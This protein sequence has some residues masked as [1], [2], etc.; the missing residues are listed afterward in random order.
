MPVSS[1]PMVLVDSLVKTFGRDVRALN[2]VSFQIPAGT[3]LGLLGPNGAGK[4][5][6]VRVLTTLLRPD[7]G[8]AEVAGIDVLANPANARRVIGLA[9]QYAAVDEALTGAENL[10]L[11]GRLNHLSRSE[12]SKRAASLLEQFGLTEARDRPLKNYSGGMRRRLDLAAALVARPPI[13]FLDEPTTGLDPGSRIDLWRVIGDLVADGATVLLTSQYLDE[14]D[15]LADQICVIDHGQVIAEGTATE[16]KGRLGGAVVE[17]T[18]ADQ[19]T[20]DA[21]F[22]ALD[23]AAHGAPTQD[24]TL[25][26]VAATSG[27]ATLTDVVRR[28][29]AVHIEA[30]GLQLRQPSLDDV[31]LALTGHGAAQSEGDGENKRRRWH[32]GGKTP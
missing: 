31:F 3:V 27:A 7:S 10:V 21:A 2:G 32:P 8:R 1:A 23:G 26:R 30:S 16:L 5:T 6:A 20:A 18:L 22:S 25:V 12:R 14:V 15:R 28:L 4:T 9:G 29:D 11:I 17:V 24:G 13:L 19:S